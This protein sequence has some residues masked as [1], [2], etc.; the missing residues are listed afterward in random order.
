[1]D[2]PNSSNCNLLP[3]I[4]TYFFQYF[5]SVFG[6]FSH[7]ISCRY[8]VALVFIGYFINTKRTFRLPFAIFPITRSTRFS[9]FEVSNHLAS[10]GSCPT[11][12]ALNM[13]EDITIPECRFCRWETEEVQH[14]LRNCKAHS[15][16]RQTILR[17]SSTLY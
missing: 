16:T 13:S 10:H 12:T 1:M 11:E 14:V 8:V 15:R 5:T 9:S 3:S 4:R 2:G 7:G 6:S 17:F